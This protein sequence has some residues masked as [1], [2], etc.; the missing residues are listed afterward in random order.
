MSVGDG[1]SVFVLGG[2]VLLGL[3]VAA[4]LVHLSMSV[5]LGV[6]S[7]RTLVRRLGALLRAPGRCTEE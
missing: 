4:V 6:V 5:L 3:A 2:A 1:P 7:P